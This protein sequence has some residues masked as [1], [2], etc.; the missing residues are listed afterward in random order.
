MKNG[1][2]K[3]EVTRDCVEASNE[4]SKTNVSFETE[5]TTS[6]SKE[7]F[8]GWLDGDYRVGEINFAIVS[9]THDRQVKIKPTDGQYTH[10]KTNGLFLS[11]DETV[12]VFG[13]RG[14]GRA[15][16]GLDGWGG[17]QQGGVFL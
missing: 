10:R 14:G 11:G 6:R 12:E 16:D 15:G 8:Q 7:G 9:V 4:T 5:A 1:E 17:R 13:K 2:M 3:D